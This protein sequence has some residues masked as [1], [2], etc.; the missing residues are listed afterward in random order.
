[1]TFVY[2]IYV[3]FQ[4][5]C[6][7]FYE[8]N[9]KDKIMHIKKIPIFEI[10][11][12]IFAKVIANENRIDETSLELILNKTEVFKKKKKITAM[13]L[14][15]RKDIIAVLLNNNGKIIKK[16]FLL[17]DEENS[18]LRNIHKIDFLPLS[19]LELEKKKAILATRYELEREKFLLENFSHMKEQE[20][21]Y[22][23]F[24]CFGEIQKDKKII[25]RELR[26]EILSGNE[27]ISSISY[28]FLK[29]IGTNS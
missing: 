20:L 8:W 16:S 27:K 1:M 10:P 19:L 21:I 29:L 4:N 24:E 28:H 22:L 6:Y 23:Y 18:I 17:L 11:E 7:D 26:R 25:E 13:L 9:K 14:T 2:D 5:V 12:E 3:N 15:N